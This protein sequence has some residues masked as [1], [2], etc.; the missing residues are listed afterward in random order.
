MYADDLLLL[1]I[2]ITDLQ[3]LIYICSEALNSCDLVVNVQKI[4]CLRIG[5]RFMHTD[6]D[7]YLNGN[8]LEWKS[9]L[10]Y[11]GVHLL[12][13]KQFHCSL[14]LAKQ[15]FYRALNGIFGKVGAFANP[16]VLISLINFLLLAHFTLWYRSLVPKQSAKKYY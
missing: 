12:N 1:S 16:Q 3:C 11:L 5:L 4:S 6:C 10:R 14:Q 9:D 15:N 2:S 8:K 13:G 7:I